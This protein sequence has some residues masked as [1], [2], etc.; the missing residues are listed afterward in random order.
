MSERLMPPKKS[1]EL[2][3][4]VNSEKLHADVDRLTPLFLE[5]LDDIERAGLTG[6]YETP[7][8][9]AMRAYMTV[10]DGA[11]EALAEER[12]TEVVNGP[13]YQLEITKLHQWLQ[14]RKQRCAEA[15]AALQAKGA[16]APRPPYSWRSRAKF[17]RQAISTWEQTLDRQGD[18]HTS[19]Q[20]LFR[21]HGYYGLTALRSF[22]LWALSLLRWATIGVTSLVFL[23]YL[24]G[25]P[26]M[27]GISPLT[28]AVVLALVL[29]I[30]YYIV[31][32]VGGA[33]AP[34]LAVIGYALAPRQ[35]VT[36]TDDGVSV[37]PTAA[38][39]RRMRRLLEIWS[40][41]VLGA[42]PLIWFA[43]AAILGVLRSVLATPGNASQALLDS[44][45]QLSLLLVLILPLS[46]LF[47]L[48]FVLYSQ[49]LLSR[50]L[51]G[52]R[53]WDIPA[54]R[55]PLRFSLILLPFEI[56]GALTVSI[57]LRQVFT[58]QHYTVLQF[59]SFHLTVSTVLYLFSFLLPYL[60]FIDLPYRY[61]VD[62]WRLKHLRKL[63]S[64]RRL[65]EEEITRLPL[66][67]EAGGDL[68]ELQYH[69]GWI[70][71][72]QTT[73]GEIRETPEA[74]FSVERRTTAILLTTPL[75]LLLAA[76]QDIKSGEA[77]SQDVL[78]LVRLLIGVK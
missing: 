78:E 5:T 51:A 39:R 69:L 11:W 50:D 7:V 18:A 56:A 72:Y 64:A 29:A 33:S 31:R 76:L 38:Q 44:L 2:Q 53:D 8:R 3:I 47:F 4:D 24:V 12:L 45:G 60:L 37:V 32:L 66:K 48:P 75:P 70:E 67:G 61:G 77:I 40:A 59:G 13:G 16:S 57:I 46:Y 1:A 10:M 27:E 63:R 65:A 52:H 15:L 58:L 26:F 68:H 71:Y 74:P 34:M 49:T 54:R 30:G 43:A 19:G 36:F 42:A 25:I 22:E 41:L 20:G 9:Q 73:M 14:E 17:Y 23:V 62:H 6:H 21:M 28:T 35:R 55:Y